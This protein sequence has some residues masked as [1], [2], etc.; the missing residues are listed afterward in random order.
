MSG[1]TAILRKGKSPK[2]AIKEL[3]GRDKLIFE[4]AWDYLYEEFHRIGISTDI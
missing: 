1:R 3:M 2:L 4:L